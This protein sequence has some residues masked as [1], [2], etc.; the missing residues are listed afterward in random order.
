MYC[1]RSRLVSVKRLYSYWQQIRRSHGL[2]SS[3][4][5][6]KESKMRLKSEI[7]VSSL[8]QNLDF[9]LICKTTPP[10]NFRY[11]LLPFE[12]DLALVYQIH[13]ITRH[14]TLLA[15]IL[16]SNQPPVTRTETYRHNNYIYTLEDKSNRGC[17]LELEVLANSTLGMYMYCTR[18]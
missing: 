7:W 1:V 8:T 3:D 16:P 15:V 11:L 13:M 4:I 2:Y 5:G 12:I 18:R 10:V 6:K 17:N 9:I 14:I